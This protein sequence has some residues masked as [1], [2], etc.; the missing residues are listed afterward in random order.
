MT[1][2]IHFTNVDLFGGPA[3]GKWWSFACFILCLRASFTKYNC[4]SLAL[5]STPT[6]FR[7]VRFR[8]VPWYAKFAGEGSSLLLWQHTLQQCNTWVIHSQKNN[9]SL[10]CKSKPIGLDSPLPHALWR[11]LHLWKPMKKSSYYVCWNGFSNVSMQLAQ[12]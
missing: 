3:E 8:K 4:L 1:T 2:P 7:Q 6:G 10:S 5:Q 12:K 9:S 11:H